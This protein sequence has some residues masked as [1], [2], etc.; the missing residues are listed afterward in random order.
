MIQELNARGLC[1]TCIYGANCLSLKN[2]LKQGKPVFHCE[3][4]DNSA[5]KKEGERRFFPNTFVTV[6]CFSM[7][8]LIPGCEA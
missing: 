1:S 8:N 7:K 2:S 5:S 3:E 4:F 6:Q